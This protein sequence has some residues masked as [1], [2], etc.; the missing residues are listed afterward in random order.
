MAL[1]T[2]L[3]QQAIKEISPNWANSSK[4]AGG[5]TKYIQLAEE[6]EEQELYTALGIALAQDL[7]DNPTQADN[8][9]LLDGGSFENCQGNTV[10]FK[11]VRYILAY[12][13]WSALID[14][15]NVA[16][17]FTGMVKKNRGEATD[18][19]EGEKKRLRARGRE[20]ALRELELLKEFLN[21]N[22]D[23]YTLWNCTTTKVYKPT[24]TGVKRTLR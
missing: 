6:V 23:T 3:Q 17:T 22:K 19:S 16:D 13:N 15:S 20:I 2:I 8:V 10:R 9:V 4:Q 21:K 24:I 1:L 5:K 7:Q 12:F 14:E 18:L 11:G